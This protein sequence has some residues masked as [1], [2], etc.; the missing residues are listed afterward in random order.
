MLIV[1][2]VRIMTGKDR[3]ADYRARVLVN[4]TPI[5]TG[6]VLGHDRDNGWTELV[7]MIANQAEREER[8]ERNHGTAKVSD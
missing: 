6:K 5:W 2:A 1:E 4:E 3:L 7:R 8:N